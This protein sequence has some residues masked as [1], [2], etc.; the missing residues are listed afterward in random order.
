MPVWRKKKKK[1]GTVNIPNRIRRVPRAKRPGQHLLRPQ[2]RPPLKSKSM[3]REISQSGSQQLFKL[4]FFVN[5]SKESCMFK[6]PLNGM[7]MIL[8][9]KA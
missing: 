3:M 5:T 4:L 9:S 7:E 2:S 8:D 1:N 6:T